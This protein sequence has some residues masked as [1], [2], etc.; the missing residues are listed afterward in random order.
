MVA[1]EADRGV[2]A[3]EARL[4]FRRRGVVSEGDE[5]AMR[6]RGPEGARRL[7]GVRAEAEAEDEDEQQ[8]SGMAG[9]ND[10]TPRRLKRVRLMICESAI[11]D[12]GWG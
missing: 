3:G 7:L 2:A 5:E 11:C 12:W 4:D 6:D 8:R 1:H 9:R 10:G